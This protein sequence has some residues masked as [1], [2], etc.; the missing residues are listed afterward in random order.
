MAAGLTSLGRGFSPLPNGYSRNPGLQAG[1]SLS[2]RFF[3]AGFQTGVSFTM[4]KMKK[5]AAIMFLCSGAFFA[6]SNMAAEF[7]LEVV[8]LDNPFVPDIELEKT[9]LLKRMTVKGVYSQYKN[10]TDLLGSSAPTGYA[11]F[12]S[13]PFR[14]VTRERNVETE[15]RASSVD[16]KGDKMRFTMPID[17]HFDY[18]RAV[19]GKVDIYLG[20]M[21][22]AAPKPNYYDLP[23]KN[24]LLKTIEI[25]DGSQ[26]EIHTS[27]VFNLYENKTLLRTI[28][29]YKDKGFSSPHD[30]VFVR[31]SSLDKIVSEIKNPLPILNEYRKS[32]GLYLTY[33]RLGVAYITYNS[34]SSIDEYRYAIDGKIFKIVGYMDLY[35]IDT[36]PFDSKRR[37]AVYFFPDGT[38]RLYFGDIR[39]D[40]PKDFP[41]SWMEEFNRIENLEKVREYERVA[42]KRT[43]SS[44]YEESDT[45][46]KIADFKKTMEHIRHVLSAPKEELEKE[47]EAY[48]QNVPSLKVKK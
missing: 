18:L 17:E 14:I 47:L 9:K 30:N 8:A 35:R 39:H 46:K 15:K 5:A 31:I 48:K 44:Y 22:E 21:S 37:Y 7:E 38:R 42:V 27:A 28:T 11:P 36:N 33:G 1:V 45:E 3:R 40:Y 4:K 43:R 12:P 2:R 25:D 19:D 20:G 24:S 26:I 32:E 34:F 6:G 13:S 29:S 41:L 10:V 16:V 23:H